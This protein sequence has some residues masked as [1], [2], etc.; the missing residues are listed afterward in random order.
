[1]PPID[2]RHVGELIAYLTSRPKD[3]NVPQLTILPTH[4][5]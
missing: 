2:A 5:V 3:V 4:Q 1:M